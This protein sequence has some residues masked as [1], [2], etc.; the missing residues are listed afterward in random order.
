MENEG[1]IA[2]L[3]AESLKRQDTMIGELREVKDELRE[4]KDEMRGVKTEI[5]KL[6]LQ[7]SEN[8]RAIMKI[9]NRIETI[10]DLES[11]VSAL[12]KIANK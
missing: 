11:R 10:A 4:V 3:L 12:E 7:T 6:N 5:M 2:E 9:A 1:R 8:S